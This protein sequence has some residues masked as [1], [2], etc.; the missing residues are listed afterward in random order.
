[1]VIDS[2]W[3]L[4]YLT[5]GNSERIQAVIQSGVV[6]KLVELLGSDHKVVV[7]K[8]ALLLIL[9]LNRSYC[10]LSLSQAVFPPNMDQQI[11]E[12]DID[13]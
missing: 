6:P 12:V 4:S 7:R 8:Q 3:A 2:C 1:M 10:V 5:D 9:F 11:C 13:S